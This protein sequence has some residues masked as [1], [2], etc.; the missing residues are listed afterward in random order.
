MNLYA[1]RLATPPHLHH[2]SLAQKLPPPAKLQRTDKDSN[3][4]KRL[5]KRQN[6]TQKAN[7]LPDTFCHWM[8]FSGSAIKEDFNV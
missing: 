2:H 1:I 6:V 3:R 4:S 5:Q 7:E 8:L